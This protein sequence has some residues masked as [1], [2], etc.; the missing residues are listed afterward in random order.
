VLAD[1]HGFSI[2]EITTTL[3][4]LSVLTTMATPAINDYVEQAK[5][6]RAQSD[7]ATLSVSLVRLFNDVGFERDRPGG[8]GRYDLL[9]GAGNPPTADREASMAWTASA[10]G[11]EVGLLDDQLVRNTAGYPRRDRFGWRGP[12]LQS[13]VRPD[14]WGM[15]YGVNAGARQDAG[16]D[17]IVLSAGP[18]GIV[19]VPFEMDGLP[20]GHDDML[21]V[22]SS[23]R[24]R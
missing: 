5:L 20:A 8:W 18:D 17:V 15:R 3:V 21:A 10:A 24:A 14:P 23:G 11:P 1:E 6:I 2:S 19:S 7:V 13:V 16:S 22:V 4:V 9:V 12:Y